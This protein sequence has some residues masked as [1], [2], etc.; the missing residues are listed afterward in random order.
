MGS[1]SDGPLSFYHRWY[2][3][4]RG[5]PSVHPSNLESRRVCVERLIAGAVR[6]M[7]IVI[8]GSVVLGGM[9]MGL[10]PKGQV[11]DRD[12][13]V[14]WLDGRR[15]WADLVRGGGYARL[16]VRVWDRPAPLYVVPACPRWAVG[17][18]QRVPEGCVMGFLQRAAEGDSTR[19]VESNVESR[20][21]AKKHPALF[22]YL[23]ELKY[24]DG[25]SRT[26]ATLLLF[27]EDG[28]WKACLKDRDTSRSLW[29]AAGSPQE[30]MRDLEA[31]LASGEVDWR[32][33]KAWTP[34]GKRSK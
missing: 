10:Q 22:E 1:H 25:G 8:D 15:Y 26:T 27:V 28:V 2:P 5:K 19:R 4:F 6:E 33:D 11:I 29:M 34:P 16:I 21:W 23:T 7:P 18:W 32:K 24:P 9:A 20:E 31:A 3:L 17:A 12:L 30:V 13:A 14:Y